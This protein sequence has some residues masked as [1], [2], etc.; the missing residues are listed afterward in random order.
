MKRADKIGYAVLMGL[1]VLLAGVGWHEISSRRHDAGLCD[2]CL[3]PL[4]AN[5]E[6]LVEIGGKRKFVCCAR[7]AI[8]EAAQERRPLEVIEV[9]DYV[10]S[11]KLD[12][13]A[14]WYVDGSH[15]VL[16]SHD[17]VHMD[18]TKRS[19]Q[20]EFDRCSP[21]AY[22]FANLVDAQSF[23][24]ENGGLIR[25]ASEMFEGMKSK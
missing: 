25:S 20:V 22:E 5:T 14:A 11:R 12:P 2:I 9:S 10:T 17:E 1:L 21:G 13:K 24:K 19:Q 3:R 16:C 18:D 7:C 8:T 15:K 4:H 6:V 23:V